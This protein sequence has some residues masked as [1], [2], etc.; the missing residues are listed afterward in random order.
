M[1]IVCA[2]RDEAER[3]A[4]VLLE[5][6][7]AQGAIGLDRQSWQQLPEHPSVI[8]RCVARDTQPLLDMQP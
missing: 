2:S 7:L 3:L 8:W 1:L 4:D 5:Y 6:G